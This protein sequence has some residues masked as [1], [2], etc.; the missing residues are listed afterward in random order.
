MIAMWKIY[1][2]C[3]L[4]FLLLLLWFR[5]CFWSNVNP[6]GNRFWFKTLKQL[7]H[8]LV[9]WSRLT[10]CEMELKQLTAPIWYCFYFWNQIIMPSSRKQRK[11]HKT[12]LMNNTHQIVHLKSTIQKLFDVVSD[13]KYETS[14]TQKKY[15]SVAFF[16]P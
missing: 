1:L 6:T 5:T 10:W 14:N 16:F 8:F 11:V 15:I 12:K 2:I 7:V 4:I 13:K 9:N 3:Y